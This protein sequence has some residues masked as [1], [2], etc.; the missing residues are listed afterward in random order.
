MSRFQSQEDIKGNWSNLLKT[1]K[2]LMHSR[3]E[4]KGLMSTMLVENS[5]HLKTEAKERSSK[6]RSKGTKYIIPVSVLSIYTLHLQLP[7]NS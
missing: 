2:F 7:P 3:E 5:N 1:N 4:L 6:V